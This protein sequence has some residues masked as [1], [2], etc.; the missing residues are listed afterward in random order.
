MVGHHRVSHV[1][2]KKKVGLHVYR[3]STGKKKVG[4]HVYRSSTGKK[5]VGLHVYRSSWSSKPS[6]FP[7]SSTITWSK[8]GDMEG[9]REGEC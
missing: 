5:K 9:F 7:D 1:T 2:G 4:L 6:R 8:Y 3:S